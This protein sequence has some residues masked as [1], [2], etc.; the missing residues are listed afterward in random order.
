MKFPVWKETKAASQLRMVPRRRVNRSSY[1]ASHIPHHGQ[2]LNCHVVN[3]LKAGRA[4]FLNLRFCHHVKG[5]VWGEKTDAHAWGRMEHRV[6]MDVQRGLGG[7]WLWVKSGAT[8]RCCAV[9]FASK[10][11]YEHPEYETRNIKG[12]LLSV[13]YLGPS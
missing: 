6:K 9:G 3:Q 12:K 4:Q 1:L 7:G 5:T 13:D 10:M 2:H 8:R 11:I